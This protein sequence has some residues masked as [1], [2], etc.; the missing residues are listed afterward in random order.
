[1]LAVR[2]PSAFCPTNVDPQGIAH[3]AASDLVTPALWS[4]V[5]TPHYAAE[6]TR[7]VEYDRWQ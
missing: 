3:D 4:D 1:M 5:H 2:K 7:A 6:A